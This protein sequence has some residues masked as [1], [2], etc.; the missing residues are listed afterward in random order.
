MCILEKKY[1]FRESFRN[2]LQLPY[3]LIVLKLSST[4][5]D[6]YRTT[7]RSHPTQIHFIQKLPSNYR[8][9]NESRSLKKIGHVT[10]DYKSFIYP[11]AI[12]LPES[13]TR[14]EQ[15]RLSCRP[16]TAQCR[17]DFD[18]SIARVVRARTSEADESS[19]AAIRGFEETKGKIVET[20]GGRRRRLR[21]RIR[22]TEVCDNAKE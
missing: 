22:R 15:S 17:R 10:F 14:R 13:K 1:I 16:Y 6:S 18:L 7:F 9:L 5:N 4:K 2:F 3:V 20:R 11:A 12:F 19:K 21:G 8:Y